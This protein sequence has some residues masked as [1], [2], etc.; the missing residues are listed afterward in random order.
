M[1][2]IFYQTEYSLALEGSY[3]K[4]P[5]LYQGQYYYSCTSVIYKFPWCA[6]EVDENLEMTKW[7]LCYARLCKYKNV[8]I[9][10][11]LK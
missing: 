2:A 9:H 4:F 7:A 3:C 1:C 10:L 6:T 11:T 5:F 8:L